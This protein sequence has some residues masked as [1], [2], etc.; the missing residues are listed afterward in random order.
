MAKRAP[1]GP[2]AP[3]V[4]GTRGAAIGHV[5]PEAAEKGPIAG[6][7]EGDIIEIDIPNCKL[8]VELTSKEMEQRLSSLPRFEPK[9]KTG[10]LK[11]YS[12]R[13]TSASTGA[14]F[15]D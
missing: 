10:F 11:R 12:D 2:Y 13:V 3:P 5:S 4:G 9:I 14:V 8:E 6:I 7:R 1:R 15:E